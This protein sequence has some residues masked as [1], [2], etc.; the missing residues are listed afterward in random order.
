MFIV[1]WDPAMY[2][3]AQS[4]ADTLFECENPL[5]LLPEGRITG[6]CRYCQFQDICYEQSKGRAPKEENYDDLEEEDRI[7]IEKLVLEERDL[8]DDKKDITKA[9]D[10]AKEKLK[11]A[12]EEFGTKKAAG[13]GWKVSYSWVAGRKSLSK[14]KLEEAG[15]DPEDFMDEGK[16]YSKLTVTEPKK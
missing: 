5:D 9:H 7:K 11:A 16:G 14:T 4:R 8:N 12:L 3:E 6:D 10:L 1:K 15:L 13:E 2:K